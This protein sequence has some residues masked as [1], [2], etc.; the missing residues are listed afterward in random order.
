MIRITLEYFGVQ[1][2]CSSTSV[3][4]LAEAFSVGCCFEGGV[5]ATGFGS[6]V[7]TGA[8]L[9]LLACFLLDLE[10]EEVLV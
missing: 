3:D 2:I 8:A 4:F 9:D 1:S 10:E 6:G 7:G 5:V